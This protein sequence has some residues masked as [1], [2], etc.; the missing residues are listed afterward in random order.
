MSN[1]L[2]LL[3]NNVMAPSLHMT[4]TAMTGYVLCHTLGNALRN[5]PT[6]H[7][8]G[9][10]PDISTGFFCDHVSCTARKK[11]CYML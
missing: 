1:L 10:V 2:K 5:A 6:W 9:T 11:L 4:H 3:I 8:E 7:Y